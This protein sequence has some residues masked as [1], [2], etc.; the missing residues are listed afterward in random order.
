MTRRF[1]AALAAAASIGLSGLAHA[2]LGDLI[3]AVDSNIDVVATFEGN[4]GASY[5]SLLFLDHPDNPLPNIFNNQ[6]TAPGTEVNLGTFASG[7]LKFGIEV[8]PDGLGGDLEAIYYTGPASRNP[9]GFTHAIVEELGGNTL[10]VRFEDLY[11]TND[12]YEDLAF[13]LTNA[14]A[15][16][17]P[18]PRTW[19]M[20][21][22]GLGVLGLL[23]LS[24]R[25][26]RLVR[27]PLPEN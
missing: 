3:F 15:L 24:R 17:V 7:E 23:G 11:A 4:G 13:T 1:A 22:A 18:E 10:R 20:L 5:T 25:P 12:T 16:P 19:A 21:L 27:A 26:A 8:Y 2:G 9:D 14:M 6:A